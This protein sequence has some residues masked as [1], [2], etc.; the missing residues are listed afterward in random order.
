MWAQNSCAN[1]L[2]LLGKECRWTTWS[3]WES[4]GEG[5]NA[6]S[7]C[8]GEVVTPL[9]GQSLCPSRGLGEVEGG[10]APVFLLK[11][12]R[13]SQGWGIQRPCW[14]VP[15]SLYLPS[16]LHWNCCSCF[17]SPTF[18]KALLVS[19]HFRPSSALSF[20]LLQLFTG[21]TMSSQSSK[22][23]LCLVHSPMS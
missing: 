9:Q 21:C 22:M 19:P 2:L 18:A 15:H 6:S 12:K 17:L 7:R 14:S 23:M 16:S 20:P 11:K 13:S 8:P 3:P 4:L 1:I 10:C 5:G